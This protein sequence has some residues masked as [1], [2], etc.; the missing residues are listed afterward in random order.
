[1]LPV[2][3][4]RAFSHLW[5]GPRA[6]GLQKMGSPSALSSCRDWQ[7][8]QEVGALLG[9]CTTVGSPA[10]VMC[11]LMTP[12]LQSTSQ[13]AQ[14]CACCLCSSHVQS[15]NA[16][17]ELRQYMEVAVSQLP[18]GCSAASTPVDILPQVAAHSSSARSGPD[19]TPIFELDSCVWKSCNSATS[20]SDFTTAVAAPWFILAGGCGT[21]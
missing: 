3:E 6:C 10:A 17:V 21:Q 9:P 16:L 11:A 18:V 2:M 20:R 13:C 8:L 12:P 19:C 14:P 4:F 1:M 5:R 7:H 15:L